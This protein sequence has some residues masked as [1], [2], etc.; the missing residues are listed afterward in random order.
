MGKQDHDY[1]IIVETII[2]LARNFN[3]RVTAE[4]VEDK[5]TFNV[6]KALGCDMIQG[7][8]TGRPVST[9]VLMSTYLFPD[10]SRKV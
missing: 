8:Y 9:D 3:L 5:A 4:G 2:Q 7:F 6:L 1:V 10:K